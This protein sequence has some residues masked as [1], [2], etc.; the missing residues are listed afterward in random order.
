[1]P[2]VKPRRAYRSD[3]RRGQAAATR[4]A[5]VAAAHSLFLARGYSGTTIDAIAAAAGVAP[6]TVYATF[7][8]KRAILDRVIA[9]SLVGDEEPVPL[10]ARPG[11]RA[12]LAEPDQRRQV[13]MFAAGIAEIMERMSPIFEV[14]RTAAPAEP[15]VAALLDRLLHQRLQGMRAFVEALARHGPLREGLTVEEASETT[16]AISSPDL[17]RLVT[18]R[19][20]WSRERYAEWLTAV[21]SGVLLP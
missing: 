8:G 9:V 14:M 15:E 6:V 20:G 12:T 4:R 16:W 3:R 5:I 21:L 19:L 7:G 13:A 2:D 1:M 11:P 18:L 17:H 10:L